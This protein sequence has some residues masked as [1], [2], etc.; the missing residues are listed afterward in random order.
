MKTKKSIFIIS[1]IC[2][3]S[4]GMTGILTAQV[5]DSDTSLSRKEKKEREKQIAYAMVNELVNSRKFVFEPIF[6]VGQVEQYVLID[7]IYGEVQNGNRNNLQGEIT[8]YEVNR[9]DKKK[10]VSVEIIIRGV[11][12]T[13][14]VVLFIG[15]YGEGTAKITGEFPENFSINGQ[16]IDLNS[17]SVHSGP[18]HFV[19]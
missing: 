10:N 12:N 3:V 2:L 5:E 8:K 4:F 11:M 14:S 9:N 13:S 19:R 17:A 7:S 1:I 15:T 18:D 6:S 16:I